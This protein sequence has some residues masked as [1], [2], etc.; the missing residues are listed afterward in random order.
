MIVPQCIDHPQCSPPPPQ[1]YCTHILPAGVLY[2]FWS[3]SF[4]FDAL[5]DDY[6]KDGGPGEV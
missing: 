1:M 4:D 6:A 5:I 2:L 3:C